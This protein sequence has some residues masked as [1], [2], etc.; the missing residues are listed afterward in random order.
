MAEA[1]EPRTIV[2]GAVSFEVERF[3]FADE[4]LELDGRW[5][6]VRGRRF[7]RPAL[8]IAPSHRVLAELEHKPWAAEDGELWQAAFPVEDAEAVELAEVE[9]AVGNDVAIKLPAPDGS[10]G[11]RQAGRSLP[12]PKKPGRPPAGRRAAAE[13]DAARSERDAAVEERDAARAERDAIAAARDAI[14]AERDMAVAERAA[15]VAERAAA[16]AARDR[17]I[18]ERDAAIAGRDEALADRRR[19]A[20][21]RKALLGE[22]DTA[23][24]DL[25]AV[26]A[27]LAADV[28]PPSPPAAPMPPLERLAATPIPARDPGETPPALQRDVGWARRALV[29]LVLVI[30]LIAF[31]IV[32]RIV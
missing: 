23:L 1:L 4:R 5:F 25:Q 32:V 7:M 24:A 8:T 19:A 22:R 29:V 11:S 27:G 12:A 26:R 17:A 3:A 6:G 31:A 16:I 30:A 28:Q 14:V 9:L 10:S 21:D 18:A 13:R 2:A 15:A 20:R